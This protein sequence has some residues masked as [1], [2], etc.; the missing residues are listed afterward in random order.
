LSFVD[1]EV[2]LGER[3][4]GELDFEID[5]DEALQLCGQ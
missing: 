2:D 4:A 1:E 5:V 3:E